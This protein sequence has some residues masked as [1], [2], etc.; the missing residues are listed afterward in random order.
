[1]GNY[2]LSK[3]LEEKMVLNWPINVRYNSFSSINGFSENYYY[4]NGKIEKQEI[5]KF[6]TIESDTIPVFYYAK[7][8]CENG[9]KTSA[10]ICLSCN[11]VQDYVLH[12]CNGNIKLKTQWCRS[13]LVGK[14]MKFYENGKLHYEGQLEECNP[15]KDIGN[16]HS[17]KVGEWKYY[18]EK[19]K[20]IKEELGNNQELKIE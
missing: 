8:F 19:G 12:Y 11:Q 20:L 18:D 6:E 16:A 4:I 9:Q 13:S 5:S 14:F 15:T 10:D 17:I 7:Y 2:D 1:L 3:F